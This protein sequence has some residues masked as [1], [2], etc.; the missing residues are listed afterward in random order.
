[1]LK[2]G[3]KLELEWA[4]KEGQWYD[5]NIFSK[6]NHLGTN[7]FVYW[8]IKYQILWL[9]SYLVLVC[10]FFYQ[11]LREHH[12][13]FSFIHDSKLFSCWIFMRSQVFFNSTKIVGLFL[14][15]LNLFILMNSSGLTM[16]NFCE[17]KVETSWSAISNR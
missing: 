5:A 3:C 17:N 13:K 7:M 4:C 11:S 15:G 16:F 12:H 8:P 1:M 9:I 14:N 2:T 10:L 6:F